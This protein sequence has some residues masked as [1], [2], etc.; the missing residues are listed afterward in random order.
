MRCDRRTCDQTLHLV[1]SND[2][3]TQRFCDLVVVLVGTSARGHDADVAGCGAIVSVVG[4]QLAHKVYACVYPV[5][6]ELE[7]VEAAAKGIV[8]MLAGEVH[9]L[10][11]GA[12]NLCEIGRASCRERVVRWGV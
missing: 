9:E 3:N 5:G 7:E 4:D 10:C 2:F 11:Q 1:L 12:S 8:A 6:L